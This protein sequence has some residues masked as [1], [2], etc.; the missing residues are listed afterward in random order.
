MERDEKD[1]ITDFGHYYSGVDKDGNPIA[2]EIKHFIGEDGKLVAVNSSD[3]EYYKNKL[4]EGLPV[5]VYDGTDTSTISSTSDGCPTFPN[6]N[7]ARVS[8]RD[9]WACSTGEK[10]ITVKELS[11]EVN[12]LGGVLNGLEI[13]QGEKSNM[14]SSTL[15]GAG[16]G[17]GVGG[18]ATAITSFVEK[19]NINCR[20]GDGLEKVSFGKSFSLGTLKDY[21]VKWNLN[22][23]DAIM[24]TAQVTDCTSWK[25]ACAT[26]KDLNQCAKAQVNYRPVGANFTVL[27]NGACSISGSVCIENYPVAKSQG[28]CE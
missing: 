7:Q 10:C 28:A 14:V 2:I 13:L 25:N 21:Y 22:V 5:A 18:L 24:P 1:N 4:Q 17:A 15:I 16:I 6:I 19:N 27:V 8:G 26:L 9:I 12:R 3:A 11:V 23:P 20:V